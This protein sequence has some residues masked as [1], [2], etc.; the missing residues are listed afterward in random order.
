MKNKKY[1]RSWVEGHYR[2][3]KIIVNGLV[4]I[5][6]KWCEGYWRKIKV[7]SKLNGEN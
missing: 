3:R 6:H 7:K 5:V 2:K 4:K 1:Y